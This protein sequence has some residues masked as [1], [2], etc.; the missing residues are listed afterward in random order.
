MQA[1]KLEQAFMHDMI[2]QGSNTR[3]LRAIAVNF[4]KIAPPPK[5][6]NISLY[7]VNGRI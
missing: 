5:K 2:I 7:F 4:Y 3:G 1:W 6:K